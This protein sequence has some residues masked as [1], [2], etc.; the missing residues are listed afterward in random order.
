MTNKPNEP[1]A[2]AGDATPAAPRPAGAPVR[3][4][5]DS[6]TEQFA[7]PSGVQ[8]T[9]TITPPADPLGQAAEQ[10]GP[11]TEQLGQVGGQATEKITPQ[12]V[13]HGTER[14]LPRTDE[15]LGLDLDVP[16]YSQV[17]NAIPGAADSST[18]EP[19]STYSFASI[20]PAPAA[21]PENNGRRRRDDRRGTLDLGLLLLRLVIGGTFIYHGLQKA[22][23]WFHGP[24]FDGIK[25]SMEGGGW[26]HVD[27]AAPMLIA[28]ELGGGVLV[29][30]GL[31]TPLAAGALLAVILDAWLWKQGMVPGFQYSAK[32]NSVEI[33]SIL[34]GITTALILTGPGRYS[35]D[36]N[37]AWSTRPF[38]G[39][40][41]AFVAAVAAAILVYIYLHGGNPLTG[42][43]P[44]E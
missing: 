40:L 5:F 33:D 4:P 7:A 2:A 39:S 26:K 8:S 1:S 3:S 22:F 30:I 34:V 31:A 17:K 41:A 35:I 28:G 37:R 29:V 38:L 15:E 20:P 19:S 10:T 16:L 32:T 42:I 27:L 12:K 6:P 13:G 23:G 25:T 24:G 18:A 11:A 14:N 44:F 21:P 36:R 43:G 9:E